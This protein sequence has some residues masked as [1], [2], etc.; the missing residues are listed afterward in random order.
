MVRSGNRFSAY[1]STNGTSWAQLGST[2]SITM[3]TTTT[4]G[5]PVTSKVDG[6]LCTATVDNVTA[7]P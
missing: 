2:Q 7:T 6:T 5:I 4:I 1:Y 3:G